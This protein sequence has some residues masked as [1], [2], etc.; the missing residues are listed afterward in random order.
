MNETEN[1]IF[2]TLDKLSEQMTQF[3][4]KDWP[5]ARLKIENAFGRMDRIEDRVQ[6]TEQALLSHV[7]QEHLTTLESRIKTLETERDDHKK[8]KREII[9][10]SLFG[11][12][13]LVFLLEKFIFKT[14]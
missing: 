13:I 10:A 1:R 12:G 3:L 4:T 11:S 7:R 2:Q 8:A 14:K 5:D 9:L 6:R